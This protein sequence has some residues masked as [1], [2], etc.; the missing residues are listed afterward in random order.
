VGVFSVAL[1]IG[2][3][4]GWILVIV[5][6]LSLTE[7]ETLSS[8]LLVLGTLSFVVIITVLVLFSVFLAREIRMVNR[9]TRFLDSVTHE[10]K[11][12]LASLKLCLGTLDRDDLAATQESELRE[13]MVDDVERLS[14]FIDDVLEAGRLSQPR[15]AHALENVALRELIERCA[16][17]LLSYYKQ[18]R[19]VIRILVPE[20]I[21]LQTDRAA[22]GIVLKNLLDNALKYSIGLEH[23]V[24]ITVEALLEE[25]R[26][27]L[28]VRDRGVGI[29]KRY[30]RKIYDRFFRA[31][32]ESVR[33]RHGT[34]LGLFVVSALVRILGG[35]LK[36]E[37]EGV[38]KGTAARISFPAAR[39]SSSK[40]LRQASEERNLEESRP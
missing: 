28:E 13:M 14:I 4:V 32:E 6:N 5:Q 2:L 7:E 10:L 35:K 16:D 27:T 17:G 19:E 15:Q 1:S 34:G 21:V 22:L 18:S 37:S 38:G 12:P 9:Q 3:L 25:R 23:P 31:P 26:L 40:S 24:E 33:V 30:L 11:T 8:W 20:D 39:S 29:P 36:I